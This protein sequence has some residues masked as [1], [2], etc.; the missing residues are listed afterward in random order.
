MHRC[1]KQ[2]KDSKF[3][4]MLPI[5]RFGTQYSSSYRTSQ[6]NKVLNK[7]VV[8]E[9]EGSHSYISL[10]LFPADK[11][12]FFLLAVKVWVLANGKDSASPS[13]SI[14]Q[15]IFL[16]AHKQ[17]FVLPLLDTSKRNVN[18]HTVLLCLSYKK[19]LTFTTH[20]GSWKITSVSFSSWQW[21]VFPPSPHWKTI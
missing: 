3:K 2:K 20:L 12:N 1:I 7:T 5:R 13:K 4:W 10:S 16:Q 14:Q 11:L 18:A 15:N 19:T 17:H 21:S 6:C 8:V 9:V